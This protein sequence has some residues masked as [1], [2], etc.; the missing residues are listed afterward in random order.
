MKTQIPDPLTVL[1]RHVTTLNYPYKCLA[2]I[3]TAEIFNT[4]HPQSPLLSLFS[5]TV[6]TTITLPPI[7][8]PYLAI[9]LNREL[10]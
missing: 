3:A 6:D 5:I 7:Q 9:T 8:A 2:I 1:C 10:S 4:T